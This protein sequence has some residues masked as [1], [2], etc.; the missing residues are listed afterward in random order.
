MK[1]SQEIEAF[2][3]DAHAIQ[4]SR[5]PVWARHTLVWMCALFLLAIIWAC[6]GKVDVIINAFGKLISSHP[7]I[8][9]KPLER[10]VIKDLHVSI[11]DRVK[12]GDV[13]VTFDTVF[14]SAD[15]E[16]LAKE[17]RIYDAQH[18]RLS[19]EFYNT[20]YTLPEDPSPEDY[21]QQKIYDDRQKYYRE[22]N[23]YFDR[24]IDRINKTRKSLEDNLALQE[25][26]LKGFLEIEGMLDKA[27]S[28]QA[29]STRDWKEAQIARMQLEADISDKKNNILVLDSEQLAREA[30]R[31]AF[32]TD[33]KI[34]LSEN[35]VKT[36]NALTNAKKDL[37]KAQQMASYVELRAPE[38]AVVHDL[39]PLSIGS[40][41]REAETLVTLVPLGGKLEVEARIRADDIGKVK[42]G[43][44]A[45]I[46]I[47][48]FPFQQYGTLPGTVRVISEDS[49]SRDSDEG[50][51][52]A[53]PA[54]YR[55]RIALDPPQKNDFQLLDRLIP[56]MEAQVEIIVGTR[57]VIEY[58]VNPLIKSFDEAIHEP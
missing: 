46:K 24:E 44:R 31:N 56:G 21:I 54:F 35:L 40:A 39:A 53:M 19:A 3:S 50:N 9:M 51:A 29:V 42:V 34:N 25:K 57:R 27:K 7:T 15:R 52:N 45:R 22:K 6:V 10:T 38:D 8:V 32:G 28:S 17:V 43:D 1:S 18:N 14:S 16:R 37:D 20:A 11:G 12:E 58:L 36:Q 26:R 30:E 2:L 48:A 4:H 41:V 13:L 23:D 49:F 55:A 5:L 47:S 33:W